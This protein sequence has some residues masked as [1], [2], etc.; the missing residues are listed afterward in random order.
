MTEEKQTKFSKQHKPFV[1]QCNARFM[2]PSEVTEAVQQ[3][4]DLSITRQIVEAYDPTKVTGKN[5][6][7]NL[8]SLYYETQREFISDLASIDVSHQAFRLRLLSEAIRQLK[9]KPHPNWILIAQLAEQAA[10]ERGGMFTN[11][12]EI[13][14]PD[15]GAIPVS[16]EDKRRG[17]VKLMLDKLLTKGISETEARASLLEMGVDERDLT[18]VQ[19]S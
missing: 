7:A 18:A 12:R 19:I 3:T 8:K 5:L 15:G 4:F 10:K 13:S 14:G 6:S 11:K 17:V 16:V 2:S 9:A 1:V